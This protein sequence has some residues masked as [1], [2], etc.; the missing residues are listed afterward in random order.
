LIVGSIA[1][2]Y[3]EEGFQN[4][5]PTNIQ[6]CATYCPS[7]TTTKFSY[8]SGQTYEYQYEADI[9]T[10]IPGSTE[11][12]SLHMRARALL[13][14]IS[15][16]EMVLR[17]G[18][19]SLQ[20]SEPSRYETRQYVD[21]ARQF[22]LSLEQNPLRFAFIDGVI[23]NVCPT[24]NDEVW[25]MNIK[26][27]IL[28]TLQ[29]TMSTLH[30]VSETT[31]TDVSG[32][33]PVRYEVSSSW[34]NQ[35]LK[36][37]K[38]LL[39][40]TERSSVQTIFQS[41]GYE[42]DSDI[43]T[44]P[45]M[46]GTHECNQEVNSQSKILIKSECVET[47]VFRP[48]SRQGSGASTEINYKLVFTKQTEGSQRSSGS[49][50]K[51]SS[52]LYDHSL[53][54]AEMSSTLREAQETVTQLCRQTET[55]VRPAAPQVFATLVK[56]M[57]VLDANNLKQLQTM[58]KTGACAKAE[59]FFKDA[60]PV[61]GTAAS[62]SMIRDLVSRRQV[63]AVE[64]E[65]LLTSIAFIK[66]PTATMIKEL[67]GLLTA[68]MERTALPVSSVINTYC[69]LNQAESPDVAAI[70]KMFE[71][72]LKYNC[73]LEGADP[74]RM[75]LALRAIG[76]A[77]NAERVTPT[78]NRC[79]VNEDTPMSVRI[80]A[81]TAYRRISCSA[82]REDMFKL[83]ENKQKDSELR[84]NAYLAVMQCADK[85]VVSRV[86][87][88]LE[89]EEVNQVGSFIWTHLTNL[90][91]TSCP[92]KSEISE[93]IEDPHLLKTFDV[94]K[95]KFSRN[96]ELSAYNELYNIGGTVE[97]NLIF[98]SGSYVPRSAS[99]NLTMNLFGQSVNLI[100][101]GGRAQGMRRCSSG[102]SGRA[103]SLRRP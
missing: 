88:L 45:L 50:L 21:N 85:A 97:S 51:R 39:G 62:V 2:P 94:D 30:G 12:S 56:Q 36:K 31:E 24:V 100:D 10:S 80:A 19:V 77:G 11:H 25:V 37:T 91:E 99:L 59:T 61:L 58:T 16:C 26:R 73:R 20:D 48:F 44:M 60:L 13:D 86:R 40:C 72:E 49:M 41:V 81:I 46:K 66:K 90:A 27:G 53:S 8:M 98:S 33:C 63:S 67:K 3:L 4:D 17:L 78:L 1:A 89:T 93:V 38:N 95:R 9:K 54:D 76:N 43:Q 5:A 71:D 83:L 68:D 32:N 6:Q 65:I 87:Q 75:L 15:P 18:D 47:H 22:K 70:I 74:A 84:I 101:V 42:A 14:V 82:S 69:K 28:S 29:N 7:G 103:R 102:T 52:L 34:G 57:R 35:K 96:I 55:D 79:A 23:E 92:M 64:A